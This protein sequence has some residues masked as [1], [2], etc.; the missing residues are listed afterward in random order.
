MAR[1]AGRHAGP[2][3]PNRLR[4][5]GLTL[6]MAGAALAMAAGGA[7]AGELDVP[8]AV[9]GVTDPIANLKVN[10]LAHTGVDPLDNGVATKVADFPS[11]GT[12]AVTGILTQGPSVG[13]LPAAAV[14]SLLGPLAPR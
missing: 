11:V 7:Q 3:V 4:G 13:E 12:T 10:P 9:A 1:H 2:S 6:S 5:A 14:S 8:A